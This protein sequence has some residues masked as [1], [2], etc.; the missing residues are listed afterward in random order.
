MTARLLFLS[1][2]TSLTYAPASFAALA[3]VQGF[4]GEISLSNAKVGDKSNLIASDNP[5]IST[6]EEA[7]DD[8]WLPLGTLNYTYGATRNKQWFFGTSRNDIAVGTFVLEGGYRQ[9]FSDNSIWS[10]SYLPT[11][12]GE[13]IW[14][15]P[16]V[17]AD[18]LE[19]A[20]AT[21]D[22]YRLQIENIAGSLFTLDMA[23]GTRVVTDEASATQS[24]T[25]HATQY[26]RNSDFYYAKG[27]YTLALNESWTMFPSI[28]YLLDDTKGSAVNNQ[29][30]G[31]ELTTLF[32]L[33]QHSFA[34]TMSYMNH[35]YR[36]HNVIF[37]Q[38]GR[39]DD[40]YSAFLAYEYLSLWNIESLSLISL[41]GY[42]ATDSSITFYD[43][44]DW[45]TS[46]GMN[47]AF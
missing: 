9:Q 27:S 33:N 42:N 31:G 37:D 30:A 8:F 35:E 43:S 22:A 40:K 3:P 19:Q 24:P 18:Q 16:Y 6:S 17:A 41:S 38:A 13:P 39:I 26:D 36:G 1:L 11:V 32:A 23:Y 34:I 45:I 2:F 25:S 10:V 5:N 7:Y 15:N 14:K 46:I 44:S 4:S 47:F 28:I 12:V 29:G 20:E 21:G